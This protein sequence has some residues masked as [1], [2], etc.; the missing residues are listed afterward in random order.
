MD[1]MRQT[2]VLSAVFVLVGMMFLVPVITE[3]ALGV[4]HATASGQP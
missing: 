4:I 1:Y 3:K 2:A